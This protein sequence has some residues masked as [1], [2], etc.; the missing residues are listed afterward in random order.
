M[1]ARPPYSLGLVAQD[2]G[3]PPALRPA[4]LSV[5]CWDAQQPRPGLPAGLRPWP[6]WSWLRT[7]SGLQLLLDLGA[8]DPDKGPNAWC[9]FSGARTPARAAPASSRL[10]PRSGRLTLA[11]PVDYERQ[12][13]YEL[14]VQGA[15]PMT[16]GLR[17]LQG[18]HCG[19]AASMT[20]LGH[21]HHPTGRPGACCLR[22]SPPPPPLLVRRRPPRRPGLGRQ[23]RAPSRWCRRARESLVALVG[24][25][26]TGTRAPTGRCAAPSTGTSTSGCTGQP[27]RGQPGGDRRV[28][29]PPERISSTT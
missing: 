14:D 22:P 28:P 18:H 25:P 26:R 13:T 3:R 6:R 29:G 1:R 24:T 19:S 11:G 12:D 10:D 20:T 16:P 5:Q 9:S 23:R 21:L 8:A 17:H 4:A 27:L 7:R 15:G 2:G